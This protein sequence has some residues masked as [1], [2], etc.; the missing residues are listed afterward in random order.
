[1]NNGESMTHDNNVTFKLRNTQIYIHSTYDTKLPLINESWSL[2]F[3]S[4]TIPMETLM[5]F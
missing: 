4:N 5:Y 2:P 3:K 1:M